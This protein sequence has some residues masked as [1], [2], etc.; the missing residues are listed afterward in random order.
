MIESHGSAHRRPSSP[1]NRR[2]KIEKHIS[3]ARESV[4]EINVNQCVRETR[5]AR[6]RAPV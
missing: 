5:T 3:P 1:S 2:I 4:V 6:A